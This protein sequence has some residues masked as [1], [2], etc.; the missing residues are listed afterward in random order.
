MP[1]CNSDSAVA[2]TSLINLHRKL[3]LHKN[4]LA[5]D[6]D[7]QLQILEHNRDL[8]TIESVSEREHARQKKPAPP[9]KLARKEGEEEKVVEALAA[10]VKEQ[11]GQERLHSVRKARG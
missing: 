11:E 6:Q 8:R 4:S 3:Q 9:T 10:S 5:L 2:S 7:G 1:F